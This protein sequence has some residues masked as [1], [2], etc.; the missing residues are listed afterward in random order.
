MIWIWR[1][2]IQPELPN[3]NP[4]EI[5]EAAKSIKMAADKWGLVADAIN[6]WHLPVT[7][8]IG[9]LIGLIVCKIFSSK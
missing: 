2:L 3:L 7:L 9:F 8:A 5:I 1:K 6:G 4:V